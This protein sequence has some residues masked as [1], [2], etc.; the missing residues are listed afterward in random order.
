MHHNRG[1]VQRSTTRTSRRYV[2]AVSVFALG[3]GMLGAAAP[4]ASAAPGDTWHSSFET[5]DPAALVNNEFEPRVNV[6]GYPLRPG[7]V[8]PE[9]ITATASGQINTGE[10]APKAADGDPSSKWLVQANNGWLRF[11]LQTPRV[12]KSYTMVTANDSPARN[13]RNWT[14]QGSQDGSTWDT[15]DTQTNQ[16]PTSLSAFTRVDY[17][18]LGSNTT[19]YKFYRLNISVNNG[20]GNTQLADW[21]LYGDTSDPIPNEPMRVTTTTGPGSSRTAKLNAGWTGTQA[22][23]YGGQ[24]LANGVA[25]AT[26]VVYDGLDLLIGDDTELSYKIFPQ[27]IDTDLTWPATYA[28]VDLE[29]DDDGTVSFAS[30]ADLRDSYGFDF[31]ARA[32]GEQKAFYGSQWNNV[33]VD[34]SSLEGKRIKK[35]LLTYDNPTG[36]QGTTFTGWVDDI[37]IAAAQPIDP[38]SLLNYVDTRRGSNGTQSFSRGLT[39]PLTAVPNGFNFILPYT[40]SQTQTMPY[41]YHRDNNAQNK[42]GLEGI[43]VSH[44]TSPWM[45]DRN[46]FLV[47]PYGASGTISGSRTDKARPFTHENEIAKPHYYKVDL[48]NQMTIEATP[49]DHGGIFRF[50][51]NN[52]ENSLRLLT[53]V[54]SGDGQLNVSGANLTGWVDGGS[55]LSIGRSRMFIAGTFSKTASATGVATGRSTSSFGTFATPTGDKVVEL[56]W[57]TSFISQDQAEKNLARE[58]TGKS[59]N[60]V[61]SDATTAWLDRLSVIDLST[62]LTATDA[63]KLQVYSDLYRLN[64]YPNSQFEDVSELSSSTPEYK[65]ASPFAQKSGSATATTTNAQIKDGKVYVNNGFWDTYRTAWPLYAFLYP[66]LAEELVDGFV[67]QYRDSG[68]ISRWSSP[69]YAD[70]MTG[71]SSDV[72][73]AEAYTAGA[74]ST[75]VAEEAYAAGLKNAT[76]LPASNVPAGWGANNIGRKGMDQ[77]TFLGYIPASQNQSTSW[78]LEGFINDYGLGKMAEGLSQDSTIDA[79]KRQRYAEEAEYLLERSSNYVNAFDP[80]V[81]FFQGRNANGT[82]ELSPDAYDPLDWGNHSYTE[83]NGWNF[84][85]HVPFDVDGLAALYG[86]SDG[87]NDKLHGIFTTPETATT[88]SIHEIYEQRDVRI[89]TWGMSNQVAHHIGY[90]PAEGGDPTTTQE[91]VRE[92]MQR[93]FVGSEIGQG[94]PGDED[95]GEMSSWHLFSALGFYPLALGSGEYTIGSPLFDEVTVKR[96]AAH[97]GDLTIT[98]QNNSRDNIYIQSAKLG[99]ADLTDVRL[100]QADLRAASTLEFV[101]SGTPQTWGHRTSDEDVRVPLKDISGDNYAT[102]VE[103]SGANIANMRDD[104]AS[105]ATTLPTANATITYDVNA[106][107]ATVKTYTITNGAAGTAAPTGW[108]LEGSHDGTAWTTLDTQSGVTFAWNTQTMPFH[109]DNADAYSHYRLKITGTTTGAGATIAEVELLAK[110]QFPADLAVGATSSKIKVDSS[111]TL[112]VATI[113]GGSSLNPARYTATVDFGDGPQ[114]ATIGVEGDGLDVRISHTFDEVGLQNALVSVTN[115]GDTKSVTST[116][117]VFRDETITGHFNNAC[118]S[119]EGVGGSCDG[120]GYAYDKAQLAL[121]GNGALVQ[122]VEK[123]VPGSQLKFTLPEIESGEPD[124][125][126]GEGGTFRL[127]LSADATQYSFIGM[128]NE[129]DQV[130]TGKVIYTDGTEDDVTIEFGDWVGKATSPAFG[131]TV[132]GLIQ[133]R[134]AGTGREDSNKTTAIFATA[135]TAIPA[136]KTPEWFVMPDK[137]GALRDGKVHVFAVADNG[138]TS[139]RTATV[140][141]TLPDEPLPTITAGQSFT[142]VLAD[143][144]GGFGPATASINWGDGSEPTA[145]TVADGKVSGTHTFA[146]PGVYTVTVVLDDG[147]R[148]GVFT[149]ILTVP[150]GDELSLDLTATPAS[151]TTLD[152]LTLTAA[153]PNDANGVVTFS[154]G[155]TILGTALA[156]TGSAT[157][158]IPAQTEGSHTFTATYGGD[159]TYR[160]GDSNTVTVT[161]GKAAT[162]VE[163]AASATGVSVGGSV[164]LTATVSP[165]VAT[166]SVTFKDGSAVL[167]TAPVTGGVAELELTDLVVGDLNVTATYG[168]DTI[169]GE[170]TSDPVVVSVGKIAPTL[171]LASSAAAVDEGTAVTLTATLPSDATGT[172]TFHEGAT[173]IGTGALAGGVATASVTLP[174]GTHSVTAKYVGDAKYSSAESAAVSI[175][176]RSTA[177]VITVGRPQFSKTSQAYNSVVKRRAVVTSVVTGAKVGD[178]V[179]FRRG[180]VTVATAKV[181]R[182]GQALVA[183][184]AVRA[185]LPVGRYN[186]VTATLVSGKASATSLAATQKF[187]VVR[188]TTKRVT[189]SGK[190]FR[191]GAKPKVTV[192]VARLSNGRV[193]TGRVQIRVGKKVVRTVKL[194]AK[195]KGKITI[196]LPKRYTKSIKVRAKY[197]P[198]STKTV[199]ARNSKQVT[200]RVR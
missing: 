97:G 185:K 197:A 107:N 161:V 26:N 41:S 103:A 60:D 181:K 78:A 123:T 114:A 14:I 124:N 15:L 146:A 196:T 172:V 24:H 155:A 79:D 100:N 125:I 115:E 28:A 101:M 89:G 175:T 126:I 58:V 91:V 153:L 72:A 87:L 80:N 120:L 30:E 74:L 13:P 85:F 16:L 63:Q 128:G 40:N 65:Y 88:S 44:I 135:P 149:R 195:R 178:K 119:E 84:A 136:G 187:R 76:A 127:N 158:T 42:P 137:P 168:G 118:L 156:S 193:A 179:T 71:T 121:P 33:Q 68:W 102:A 170:S 141:G 59:F 95:N 23:R 54:V 189:I 142:A 194:T 122:G 165:A 38:S 11:E 81:G 163:L 27:L 10:G 46:Q 199:K 186:G 39:A 86:G 130:G 69:G 32:Y 35:I 83:T 31:N 64:L 171:A 148:S 82:W 134:L 70:L 139:T 192:R 5:G 131:N 151:P 188:A 43:G 111:G 184:V 109:V 167:G 20:D 154:E 6:T 92:V 117:L 169:Y 164:T 106:E 56:R 160:A 48:D 22:L 67:Q 191:A 140:S 73:F 62:S 21:E 177:P 8:A 143:I 112:K 182:Q 34:L 4:S 3:L 159:G 9:E 55:G 57:A 113:D 96:G 19:A 183:S 52:T 200:V 133:T 36:Q 50:T 7:V 129:G 2:A 190:R 29:L 138:D 37:S 105:T 144:V 198:K 12:I 17:N 132:V 90:I 77:S 93:L 49:T 174:V 147:T 110:V 157:L 152:E 75:A 45:G 108:T 25:K 51:N 1:R 166:G 47:T 104:V 150:G 180:S 162:T 94:F 53:D 145:G 99:G 66:D 18:T 176:V 116:V 61:L 173:E 98:A